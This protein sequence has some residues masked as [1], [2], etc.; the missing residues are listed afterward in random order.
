MVTKPKMSSNS[1]TKQTIK[2]ICNGLECEDE[3]SEQVI[4]PVGDKV[5]VLEVCIKCLPF[6]KEDKQVE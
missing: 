1:V 6:F 5:I 2:Q 3:A 4:V